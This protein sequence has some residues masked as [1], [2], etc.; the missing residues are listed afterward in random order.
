MKLFLLLLI[1]FISL[2]ARDTKNDPVQSRSDSPPLFGDVYSIESHERPVE[3]QATIFTLQQPHRH[4]EE[5]TSTKT[6][7]QEK[8]RDV[9]TSM[10][11]EN[12]EYVESDNENVYNNNQF[13]GA[14]GTKH[15]EFSMNIRNVNDRLAMNEPALSAV[16]QH[17]AQSRLALLKD[18]TYSGIFIEDNDST[19]AETTDKCDLGARSSRVSNYLKLGDKL[20]RK[21][22]EHE[23]SREETKTKDSENIGLDVIH[24]VF[25]T[26]S[27]QGGLLG[28]IVYTGNFHCWTISTTKIF[29]RSLVTT[30]CKS[31]YNRDTLSFLSLK[32]GSAS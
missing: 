24:D 17:N 22:K 21:E 5:K 20:V 16:D 23:R 18:D 31:Y 9:L 1:C 2:E 4:Q 25:D 26:T 13:L 12:V 19:S 3:A 28:G 30:I 10:S 27:S 8:F 7:N 29:I 15:E 14:A 11:S 32:R 6:Y